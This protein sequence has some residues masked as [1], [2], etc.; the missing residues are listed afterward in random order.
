M[1]YGELKNTA[2]MFLIG[3]NVLPKDPAVM[4]A[5][6]RAAYQFAANKCTALKLL[7]TNRGDEI[8]RMGPGNTYIRMP[9]L[10]VEDTDIL[11]IDDELGAA[12]ARILAQYTAKELNDRNYHK[13]EALELMRDYE[14]KVQEFIEESKRRGDY[15]E[16]GEY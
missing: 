7:T 8:M 3:D 4:Q 9:E 1:T 14:G 10:P 6:V 12:I 5:A 13:G 15:A 11:D 2:K 16:I